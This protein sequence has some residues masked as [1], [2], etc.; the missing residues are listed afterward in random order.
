MHEKYEGREMEEVTR[1]Y[2][3]IITQTANTYDN[4]TKS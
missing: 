1:N 3:N 4:T 2:G